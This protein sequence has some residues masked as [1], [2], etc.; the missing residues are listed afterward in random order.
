LRET[1]K[2]SRTALW[3]VVAI[4][5]GF[6]FFRFLA[7]AVDFRKITEALPTLNL[8]FFLGAIGVY[9][10]GTFIIS[11]RWK[12]S[13]S[14]SGVR[15]S[16]LKTWQVILGSIFI[17]NITPLSYVAG[18]PI[19]RSY[20]M[21]KREDIP[22]SHS[23]AATVSEYVVELTISASFF[24]LGLLLALFEIVSWRLAII[25][26]WSTSIIILVLAMVYFFPRRI[27]EKFLSKFFPTLI[28]KIFHRSKSKS[29]HD[30]KKF[31]DAGQKVFS[32]WR[33]AAKI[34]FLSLTFWIL[35]LCR[36]YLVFRSVGYTPTI[37]TLLLGLTVP[38]L[39]GLVPF[40]PGGLGLV[41][42]TY[43][44]VF[45]LTKVPIAKAGL[46]T[47]FDRL[48]ILVIGSAIGACV[49]SYMGIRLKME[50]RRKQIKKQGKV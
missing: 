44:S 22:I 17:T 20:L 15:I 4:I 27:G 6:F 47:I 46:A 13:L 2:G 48:I 49:L 19:V 39:A 18:D 33:T 31:Y 40:L 3:L 12:V 37:I 43:F 35:N 5:L 14:A 36:L 16:V 28:S 10:L 34:F 25:A 1:L 24:M 45:V 38:P 42:V 7:S 26:A 9:L 8:V 23:L 32:N 11:L 21:R 41:E 50:N 30:V 29:K